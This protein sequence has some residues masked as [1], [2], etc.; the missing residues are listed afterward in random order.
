MTA[1]RHS[2][3]VFSHLFIFRPQL[4]RSVILLA[5]MLLPL[6]LAQNVA[7]QSAQPAFDAGNDGVT[8]NM[9]DADIRSVIQWV[10]DITGKNILVHNAVTG[11]VTIIS[12][13]PVSSEEAYELFLSALQV[14][15]FAAQENDGVISIVP[16]S[17]A[18]QG[19]TPFSSDSGSSV[20]TRV[21]PVKH[22]PATQLIGLLRP[23]LPEHSQIAADSSSNSLV[24]V[25]RV[26]NIEKIENILA[27]MDKPSNSEFDVVKLKHANASDI[28]QSLSQLMPPGGDPAASLSVK[29]SVDER[30]NS[31][32][33]YGDASRRSNLR[34][35]ITR[36]DQPVQGDGSTQVVYLNYVDATELVPILESM[37]GVQAQEQGQERMNVSVEASESTNA[38]VISAPPALMSD[39]KRVVSQID[40]RKAQVLIEA[41]VVQ[42]N[43]SVANDIGVSWISTESVLNDPDGGVLSAVN[44]LGNLPLAAVSDALSPVPNIGTDFNPAAGLTFGFF[45]NGSLRAAIRALSSNSNANILSTPTIIALDNEEAELLVGQ[46]VPFLTGQSTGSASSTADPFNTIE[47][48]DIGTSL[49]V[50]PRINQ[51]DSIA[52]QLEQTTETID[53]SVDPAVADVA[54]DLITRKTEMRTRALIKDGEV[55]VIGGLISDEERERRSKVPVLGD[56]P[57]L[58][59]LFSSKG[60]TKT[61]SNLM[62]FI[63]PVILKDAAHRRE[64]TK[65]RYN[66]MRDQQE[67]SDLGGKWLQDY[68]FKPLLPQFELYAPGPAQDH[69][70]SDH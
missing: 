57:V 48:Q 18:A 31:V 14:N 61:K 4:H 42:V 1:N 13:G 55:L 9:R 3:S 56:I 39:M 49:R 47:R 15:G 59:K 67:N 68:K 22:I 70:S 17:V 7:A 45:R 51:G 69:A 5:V 11:N 20:V 12:A 50:T 21:L 54:T 38:L 60:V 26:D 16:E 58:G 62:V 32:L 34:K 10:S 41:L 36:L 35:L 37:A 40:I 19:N 43:N 6:L 53:Q 46:S 24:V 28:L 25:D 30:S 33:M 23:L 8:M 27:R 66:F 29:F 52:L 2:G 64:L 44:T 63:H 65:S